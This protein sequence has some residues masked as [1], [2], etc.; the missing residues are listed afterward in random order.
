MSLKAIITIYFIFMRDINPIID[1]LMGEGSSATLLSF[2]ILHRFEDFLVA[3]HFSLEK[4]GGNAI[5]LA[6][7][8]TKPTKTDVRRILGVLKRSKR[9]VVRLDSLSRQTGLYPDVLGEKLRYFEPLI[10]LDENINCREL[11]PAMEEYL[12]TPVDGGKRGLEKNK[13]IRK[14]DLEEFASVTDFV[15]KRLTTVGGLVDPSIRLSDEELAIL[16]RLIEIEQKKRKV[17]GKK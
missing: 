12:D 7:M 8:E 14:K 6:L 16:K 4:R 3:P 5:L 9:K 2:T 15:Y 1:P 13:P 17:G 11:I 10:M